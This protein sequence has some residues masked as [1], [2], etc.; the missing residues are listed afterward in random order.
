VAGT[1]P[2]DY[3]K[4][5]QFFSRTRLTRA[6]KDHAGMVLR[7]SITSGTLGRMRPTC[8]AF[9]PARGG[10]LFARV[11]VF[12]GNA[13]DPQPG[14]GSPNTCT[15]WRS[16]PMAALTIRSTRPRSS[17]TGSR[18][19]AARTASMPI[20][21]CATKSC[22]GGGAQSADAFGG[23]QKCC[24]NSMSRAFAVDYAVRGS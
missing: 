10:W 18:C 14:R 7:R 20:T 6:L 13:W 4:P 15:S 11:R 5:E 2:D 21:A 12:V 16:S 19:R 8:P 24:A 22:R 23:P 3:T 1:A 9:G 17:S